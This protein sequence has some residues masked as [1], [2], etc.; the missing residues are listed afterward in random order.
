MNA[1]NIHAYAQRSIHRTRCECPPLPACR[2]QTRRPDLLRQSDVG[3]QVRIVLPHR[4]FVPS[5]PQLVEDRARPTGARRQTVDLKRAVGLTQCCSNDLKLFEIFRKWSERHC[6][7]SLYVDF[8]ERQG[9]NRCMSP[10][11]SRRQFLASTGVAASRVGS[12]AVAIENEAMRA[13]VDRTSGIFR[14]IDKSYRPGLG[15]GY[16]T[17]GSGLDK[18]VRE[19]ILLARR[20]WRKM[21]NSH[22]RK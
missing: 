12:D 21:R 15:A 9:Q 4:T 7:V 3:I 22:L 5:E 6:G 2:A 20:N 16:L 14:L 13:E 17:R 11:L 1:D 19:N 10:R 8:L 18:H